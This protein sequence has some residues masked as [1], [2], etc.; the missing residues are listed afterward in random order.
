METH[1]IE[2]TCFTMVSDAFL[3]TVQ[4][5]VSL[6]LL[7][8]QSDTIKRFFIMMLTCMCNIGNTPD[9]IF[10]MR[11]K[12]KDTSGPEAVVDFGCF[13]NERTC[14]DK[15]LGSVDRSYMHG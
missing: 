5:V 4:R 12:R 2:K 9:L 8:F 13:D 1:K 3:T 14:T 11:L 10:E 7:I 6:I 15:N